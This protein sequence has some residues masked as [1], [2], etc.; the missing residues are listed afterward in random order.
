M[1][2]SLRA[3]TQVYLLEVGGQGSVLKVRSGQVESVSPLQPK[4][5]TYT[6]GITL[7][8]PNAND[9][10]VNIRVKFEDGI[11]DYNQVPSNLSV[12]DFNNGTYLIDNRMELIQEIESKVQQSRQ[13]IAANQYHEELIKAGTQILQQLNPNF[14]KEVERDTAIESLTRQV[15]ALTQ[16]MNQ[17]VS[18]LSRSD[19]GGESTGAGV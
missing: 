1:F 16:G 11:R 12:A 6:P 8:L 13:H 4:Y 18:R 15:E 10:V 7:G 14:A 9:T 19:S 17:L 3:G 5:N 2:S